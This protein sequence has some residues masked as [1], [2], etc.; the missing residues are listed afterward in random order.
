MPDLDLIKQGEQDTGRVRRYRI[1]DH[2]KTPPSLRAPGSARCAARGQAP[3]SNLGPPSPL[4]V[5]IASSRRGAP[6][7]DAAP[8]WSPPR[9][10]AAVV[11]EGPPAADQR[12]GEDDVSGGAVSEAKSG[13][14]AG[15]KVLDLTTVV[16]GPVATQSF[17]DPGKSAPRFERKSPPMFDKG[18]SSSNIDHLWSDPWRTCWVEP[19][20]WHRPRPNLPRLSL[21]RK[22][23]NKLS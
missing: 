17:G 12:E 22:R 21:A 15:I 3:R 4:P 18:V 16:L 8:S 20:R 11:R 1:F 14:L 23:A 19:Y 5:E 2:L 13:P 6:R 9:P 7:N 10:V